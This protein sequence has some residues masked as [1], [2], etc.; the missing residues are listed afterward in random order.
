MSPIHKFSLFG[1]AVFYSDKAA[2]AHR[3]A[4]ISAAVA[5]DPHAV[6]RYQAD[7]AYYASQAIKYR[8]ALVA[9]GPVFW[10]REPR[11]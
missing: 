11:A 1:W 6:S 3:D 5:D 7:A 9:A 8:L 2:D 10:F 4:A